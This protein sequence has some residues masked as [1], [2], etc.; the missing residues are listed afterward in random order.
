MAATENKAAKD[1]PTRVRR[2]RT[3]ITGGRLI[4]EVKGKEPGFHYAF[5][6]E[7]MVHERLENGF[8]HVRHPVQVGGKRIDVS[9]MQG[10]YVTRNLGRGLI[11]YL[12]RIPQEFYEEDMALEQARVD[13]Q[14]RNRVRDISSDGLSGTIRVKTS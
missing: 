7:E 8:E 11:G 13:E 1:T 9:Q 4:L 2:E 6:P 5:V 14:E 12:M 10:S 3:P